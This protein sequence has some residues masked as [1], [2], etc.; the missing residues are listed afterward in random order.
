M[1]RPKI[2]MRPKSIDTYKL[3]NRIIE[4]YRKTVREAPFRAEKIKDILKMRNIT[5][6][7]DNGNI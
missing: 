7:P 4:V 6:R 2:I 1:E 3:I 5:V